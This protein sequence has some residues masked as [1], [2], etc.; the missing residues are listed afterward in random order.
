MFT[1][2]F[3]IQTCSA[4]LSDEGEEEENGDENERYHL[5]ISTYFNCDI[6]SLSS[7]HT[8]TCQFELVVTLVMFPKVISQAIFGT[9]HFSFQ[10]FDSP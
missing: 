7:I 8:V 1:H 4:H 5:N 9:V 2:Y 10:P 3:D 6:R